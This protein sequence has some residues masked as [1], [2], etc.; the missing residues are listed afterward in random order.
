MA[1]RCDGQVVDF[2]YDEDDDWEGLHS[3][4]FRVGYNINECEEINSH[5]LKVDSYGT[6]E[7]IP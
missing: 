4:M 1:Y 2:F 6:M 7:D 5:T 3:T